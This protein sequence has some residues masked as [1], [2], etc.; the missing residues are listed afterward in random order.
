MKQMIFRGKQLLA[1]VMAVVIMGTA[2]DV[3][4]AEK[5]ASVDQT[6]STEERCGYKHPTFKKD[7]SLE[8]HTYRRESIATADREYWQKFSN[9]YYYNQ[10][11]EDKK[12]IWDQ[13]EERCIALAAG[14]EDDYVV[15]AEFDNSTVGMS[16]DDIY[17]FLM[18]F[19]TANPQYY[20]LD[21]MFGMSYSGST[22][23]IGIYVYDAFESGAER[24]GYTQA[25]RNQ[26][27]SWV[28]TVAA[29]EREEG[30]VK[31]AHDII[32]ENTSYDYNDY[33]QSAYSVV[34]LGESVCAGYEAAFQMLMN[35][36]GIETIGVTSVDHAWNDVK[37]HGQWYGV[38]TTWDD[39][40]Y[41]TIYNYYL[42][43]NVT[44]QDDG[45]SSHVPEE[46]WAGML[47]GVEYDSTLCSY[48]EYY[49]SY[50]TQGEYVYF[51]V[52]DNVSLANRYA[53]VVDSVR[54]ASL[55]EVPEVVTYEDN[56]YQVLEYS[57]SA[58][59]D[60]NHGTTEPDT[61]TDAGTTNGVRQDAD[62][63]WRYYVN[64]SVA[65][66]YTG[67]AS[68]EYGWWYIRNG[69]V[70]F[71]Y[72][73]VVQN[74]AGWWCVMGGQVRFDYTGLASNEYGWWYIENGAVNFNY[75]GV[76]P[77]EAGWWC[78]MGGQ[79]RFDYTGLASNE[80]GWWYIE[81]GAV[82]FNYNGVVPNEAGWWCIMGGKVM[83]DYTG[84]ASNEY[85]WWYING[86]AVDFTYTGLVQNEAGWWYVENGKVMFEYTGAV[87]WNGVTY[88]VV[89][90]AVV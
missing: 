1:A 35:A 11:S 89:G 4:A 43:S 47:P 53:R 13:L 71:S 76:V 59:G 28:A 12:Q 44:M 57:E 23:M 27:D 78:V 5:D 66:Y 42:K 40:E 7:A 63:A 39:Q 70:D 68:N 80:F 15:T 83:F 25:F 51:K 21:S 17:N 90:G 73:G 62:G 16:R 26:V 87:T 24:Q 52:N 72:N 33:D 31:L 81:N 38:D 20:F 29:G 37:L 19:R 74:E 14:T 32:A 30:K 10:L 34:C 79:V 36:V 88:N 56:S 54:G 45:S 75:N 58:G 82:N 55:S 41:Y 46:L 48:D 60:N 86:G 84:L 65:W 3:S 85:G 61:G 50:F 49:P 67:L 64:G 18:Y 8:K 9:D 22:Y 6:V 69:E 2:A 77:N